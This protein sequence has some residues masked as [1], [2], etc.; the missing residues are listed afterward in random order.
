MQQK[1]ER[2]ESTIQALPLWI[3]TAHISKEDSNLE[4]AKLDPSE[5]DN[6]LFI[7]QTLIKQR[8]AV[9]DWFQMCQ[10]LSAEEISSN[11]LQSFLSASVAYLR[12]LAQTAAIDPKHAL[13]ILTKTVAHLEI[14]EREVHATGKSSRSNKND[15]D[16][17]SILRAQVLADLGDIYL[18]RRSFD[19]SI[20]R[21]GQAVDVL[22]RVLKDTLD[23]TEQVASETEAASDETIKQ[24]PNPF[25]S[26]FAPVEHDKQPGPDQANSPDS[27]PIN[28]KLAVFFKGKE[29]KPEYHQATHPKPD[30]TP[31]NHPPL[32]AATAGSAVGDLK[33][34]VK[35]I[36]GAL[37]RTHM[38]LGKA[39][40]A[41][42][43]HETAASSFLNAFLHLRNLQGDSSPSTMEA[44]V[45]LRDAMRLHHKHSLSHTPNRAGRGRL[46]RIVKH[47]LQALLDCDRS[48][49]N[50]ST[51]MRDCDEYDTNLIVF[52]THLLFGPP[53]PVHDRNLRRLIRDILHDR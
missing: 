17:I 2:Q 31:P 20:V 33:D 22:D 1:D 28:R 49:S 24:F 7:H 25:P 8:K 36:Q 27:Q 41:R 50:P 11:M 6:Q 42:G 26:I 23:R 37:A 29:L 30:S 40:Q 19:E 9:S 14:V 47:H 16:F 5:S 38:Q 44:L 10:S 32:V 45:A 51:R 35:T 3:A 48:R 21:S 13:R 18:Q 43:D 4:L 53:L 46:S 15:K 12:H 34:R 39:Y 52:D